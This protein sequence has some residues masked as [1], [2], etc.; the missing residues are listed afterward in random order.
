MTTNK[1]A[2][3]G[4]SLEKVAVAGVEKLRELS[5]DEQRIAYGVVLGLRAQLDMTGE[6][7]S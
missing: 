1:K 6:N 2:V 7:A 3:E 5:P 4:D